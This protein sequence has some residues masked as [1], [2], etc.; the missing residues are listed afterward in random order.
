L[1]PMHL[2]V[3]V[4]WDGMVYLYIDVTIPMVVDNFPPY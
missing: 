2:E 3:E 1:V 4:L